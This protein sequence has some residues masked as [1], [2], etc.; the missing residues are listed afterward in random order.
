MD[1]LPA[2]DDDFRNYL[3]AGVNEFSRSGKADE[4]KWNEFSYRISY[5]QG[6]FLKLDTFVR[7][8]KKLDSFDKSNKQRGTRL[9]YFAV[10]PRFIEAISDSLY[11]LKLCHQVKSDRIVVE[12]PFGTDLDSSKKLNRFLGKRFKETSDLPN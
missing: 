7:L 4:K 2:S 11:K 10:A 9:F 6:D 8:G 12:K 3:L 1:F 5:I